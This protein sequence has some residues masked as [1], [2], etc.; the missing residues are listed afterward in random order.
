MA[1]ILVIDDDDAVRSTV[2]RILE[3]LGHEVREADDGAAGLKLL[4]ERDADLVITDIFMPGQDGIVTVGRIRKEF[5]RVKI[6]AMSGGDST[7]RMDLRHDA[8]LMGAAA[9]LA[10]PFTPGDL[11]ETVQRVLEPKP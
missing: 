6:I 10:K 5:P 8:V 1:R 7:G 3:L 11:L 9:S 4:G 2:R